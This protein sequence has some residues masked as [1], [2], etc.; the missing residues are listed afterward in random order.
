MEISSLIL[1]HPIVFAVLLLSLYVIFYYGLRAWK[2]KSD[3][4][5][6]ISSWIPYFGHIIGIWWYKLAYYDKL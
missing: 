2:L 1:L 6:S 5:P 4:P 3:E